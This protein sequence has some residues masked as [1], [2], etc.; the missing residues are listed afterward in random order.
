M[1]GK[2]GRVGEMWWCWGDHTHEAEGMPSSL[3]EGGGILGGLASPLALTLDMGHP[4]L[5]E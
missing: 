2:T 5:G 1:G 3:R 4:C